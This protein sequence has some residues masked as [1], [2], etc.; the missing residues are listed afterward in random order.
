MTIEQEGQVYAVGAQTL[1]RWA[2]AGR[3]PKPVRVGRRLWWKSSDIAAHME[4]LQP[5]EAS[6]S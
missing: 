3:I 5:E 2:A 4:G 1:S 6:K